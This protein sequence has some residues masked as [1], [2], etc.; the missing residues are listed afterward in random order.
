MAAVARRFVEL[1]VA[2][3]LAVELTTQINTGVTNKRRLIELGVMEV[4]ASIIIAG[5]TAGTLNRGRLV[6]AGII[7]RVAKEIMASLG[8]GLPPSSNFIAPVYETN[9]NTLFSAMAAE[10]APMADRRKPHANNVLKRLGSGFLSRN[11]GFGFFHGTQGNGAA[12]QDAYNWK[13]GA[14]ITIPAGA[15]RGAQGFVFP[16]LASL[17]DTG[18]ALNSLGQDTAAIGV[19]CPAVT[20]TNNPLIGVQDGTA[21]LSLAPRASSPAST[22]L[23]R[24]MAPANT[25]MTLMSG[26]PSGTYFN[27]IGMTA[28]RRVDSTTI[29]LSHN[30]VPISTASTTSVAPTTSATIKIGGDGVLLDGAGTVSAWLVGDHTAA[31]IE[32]FHAV[33]R[34]YLNGCWYGE[35]IVTNTGEGFQNLTVDFVGYGF[36]FASI[37]ACLE[38]RRLGLNAV[39]VGDH[40]D[41]T[42]DYLGGMAT[43]GQLTAIDVVDRNTVRG[44]YKMAVNW[45]QIDF[46]GG[47]SSTASQSAMSIEAWVMNLAAKRMLDATRTSAN[48]IGFDI[49]VYL[50]TG[51]IVSVQKTGTVGGSITLADGRVI[52]AKHFSACDYEGAPVPLIAGLS[53]TQGM[54]AAG[55]GIESTAGYRTD[56]STYPKNPTAGTFSP[57]NPYID[58]INASSGLLPDIQ[59][60]PALTNGA[61]DQFGN[62]AMNYRPN[63]RVGFSRYT[64]L[65]ITMPP[66]YNAQ[67]Y[68]VYDRFFAAN[69]T[70]SVDDFFNIVATS[71]GSPQDFNNAGGGMPTTDLVGSGVAY[72]MAT[73][74]AQKRAILDDLRTH[75]MGLFYYLYTASGIPT[76]IRNFLNTF[77]GYDA[78]NSLDPGPGKPFYF[79]ELGYRRE[80]PRRIK[81]VNYIYDANDAYEADGHT[82]PR[83]GY[84]T[85]ALASYNVDRHRVRALVGDLGSGVSIVYQGATA[86]SAQLSGGTDRRAPIPAEILMADASELT[87]WTFPT[88]ASC[89]A[90][91]YGMIRMEYVLTMLGQASGVLAY[92]QIKNNTTVQ[93]FDPTEFRNTLLASPF[94]TAPLLPQTT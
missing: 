6:E 22:P 20:A 24:V 91:A 85:A 4:A 89:T 31:D 69:P 53:Y 34:T 92:L 15:V 51:G 57:V 16:T 29:E 17:A 46:Y 33:A 44:V 9:A 58:V 72:S 62:Q 35:P 56:Y 26:R 47:A 13:T 67:R 39:L 60:A 55:T 93:N 76:N 7:P 18:I 43:A 52:T 48:L 83:L 5:I 63:L 66:G 30:G 68:V 1:G 94:G 79:P 8:G 49:P 84:N 27:G 82:P 42:C 54:E 45:A 71:A 3:R 86:Q 64:P 77:G 38:A 25:T 65:H 36:T 78:F 87:N 70:Y 50:N 2:P 73:T 40:L 12:T 81:R 74:T 32:L 80:P 90:F 28:A 75:N 37:A 61:A 88:A 14:K 19:L 59:A 23:A 41:V 11:K 21:G 10:S